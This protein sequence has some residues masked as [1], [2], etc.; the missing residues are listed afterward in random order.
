MDTALLDTNVLVYAADRLSSL[1]SPAARLVEQALRERGRFC[2]S[3]QNLIEFSAVVSRPRLVRTPLAGEEL[4]RITSLLYRSRRLRK[5]YPKR[6]TALR[7]IHEGTRLG[8]SGPVWYDLYLALTM[9]D[10]G[11]GIIVT[12]D[13][14]H[15]QRF[16]SVTALRI[17]EAM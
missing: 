8:I 10:A 6:G 5:I 12:E 1:H 16:S 14:G 3:P 15:F 4:I 17:A 2:I 9:R 7:T 13:V 11:I